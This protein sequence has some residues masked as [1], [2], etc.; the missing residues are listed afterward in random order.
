MLVEDLDLYIDEEGLVRSDSSIRNSLH[1]NVRV[2]HRIPLAAHHPTTKPLIMDTHTRCLHLG[3]G[4]KLA[5]V[6]LTG[7]W[8][9][10]GRQDVMT[11]LGICA[12]CKR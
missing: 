10:R 2:K 9:H 5:E 3:D 6:R 12:L 8:V 11:V 4:S 7:Y 1:F